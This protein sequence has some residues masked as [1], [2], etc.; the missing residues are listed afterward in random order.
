MDVY[1]RRF[2]RCS[3][4]GIKNSEIRAVILNPV[5]NVFGIEKHSDTKK[6]IVQKIGILYFSN[7]LSK[8]ILYYFLLSGL[9]AA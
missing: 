2:I 4:G 9:W 8:Q 1:T 7:Q 3:L 6:H 5:F